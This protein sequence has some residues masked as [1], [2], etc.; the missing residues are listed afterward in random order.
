MKSILFILFFSF[1]ITPFQATAGQSDSCHCFRNR[2]YDPANR[3]AAD[4]Y[5]LTSSFN[6]LI[7]V[8]LQVSKKQ[9]VMMKMKGGVDPDSLLAALYIASR[10]KMPVNVLLA[11]HGSG[12]SWQTIL[13]DP[14]RQELTQKNPVL[15]QIAA[16]TT[17]ENTT[18]L[19]TNTMLGSWYQAEEERINSLRKTDFSNKEIALLFAL[20]Q[21][22]K[23]PIPDLT[24]MY[25]QG[26][27]SWSEICHQF[28]LSPAAV[29]KNI[30]STVSG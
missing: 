5:L 20:Q 8:T 17:T 28:K 18:R 14:A 1:V 9:I 21:Q 6:A 29:G 7:A 4:D 19:V 12:T 23:T 3:F 11:I 27:M 13:N 25:R 30:L 16:G 26:R 22:T 2:S 15:A 24:V 10:T